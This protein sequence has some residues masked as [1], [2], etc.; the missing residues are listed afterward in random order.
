MLPHELD[1]KSCESLESE[2][3][4]RITSY[5]RRDFDAKVAT[6]EPGQ[7]DHAR[8][9]LFKSFGESASSGLGRL[10][11][12]PFELLS[13]ICLLLDLQSAL[14]FS[15]ASRSARETIG[16]IPQYHRL[17]E[18]SLECIWA[19]SRTGLSHH[20]SI[21]D[22]HAALLTELC[23][24]CGS[25][26]GFLFLPSATRCCFAC[27][28]SA[29]DFRIISFHSLQKESRRLATWLKRSHPVIHS[30]PGSYSSNEKEYTSRRK[31][32][33]GHHALQFPRADHD[34]DP[35]AILGKLPD[36]PVLR[37]MAACRLPY[38]NLATGDLQLGISC[39]GCQIAMEA[40][41]SD[42]NFSRRERLYSRDGFMRHFWDC[43]EA[44]ELW[45]SSE[46]GMV[47]V[48]E[49]EWTRRGGL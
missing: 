40:N 44:K 39:K 22:L 6:A 28:E 2:A 27:I 1:Q 13:S 47:A 29:P 38:L 15:Q 26:G 16:S 9:S 21:S 7:H 48:T 30:I 42:A 33:S 37:C 25:F 11:R 12:L 23:V 32:V 14:N 10:Q 41:F 49:P 24:I 43:V 45:A 31:L 18:H 8:S 34:E 5:H 36:S 17:R 46:A 19:L 3:I 20:T 35:Q 4:L